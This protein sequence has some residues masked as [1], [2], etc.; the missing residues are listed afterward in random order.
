MKPAHS[1]LV[2]ED[3]NFIIEG[4]YKEC[5]SSLDVDV[6]YAQSKREAIEKIRCKTYRIAIVDIMLREDLSDRGGIDVIEYIHRLNKGTAVI[7]VSATDDIEVALTTYKV[8]ISDFIQK[9]DI[10][11]SQDILGPIQSILE[12]RQQLTS[13]DIL[14]GPLPETSAKPS[15]E[16]WI[17]DADSFS[18]FKRL[19]SAW[20]EQSAH[21]SSS[22][23][24]AILP[25][26]QEIIGM[27]ATA[28]PF[29][30]EELKAQPEH[31]FWALR[32]ITGIDPVASEH[33]GRIDKMTEA[34]IMWAKENG[35]VQ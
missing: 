16:H 27:G 21:I 31:W 33:V 20:R 5:L 7:V 28:L 10:H 12:E 8:G 18:R 1:V 2:V 9:E 29:I 24:K 6:D 11:S 19:S 14:E 25:P 3:D 35:L 30:F 15:V 4:L 34:W 23:E 26:Y 32:A 13:R 22:T 17:P